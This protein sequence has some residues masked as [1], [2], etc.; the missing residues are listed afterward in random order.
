MRFADVIE[1]SRAQTPVFRLGEEVTHEHRGGEG[2][3]D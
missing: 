3:G 2:D 1:N